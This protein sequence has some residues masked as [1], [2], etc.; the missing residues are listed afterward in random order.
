MKGD[1]EMENDIIRFEDPMQQHFEQIAEEMDKYSEEEQAFIMYYLLQDYINKA[2]EELN[3]TYNEDIVKEM[4]YDNMLK[5]HIKVG[6]EM[7]E[8]LFYEWS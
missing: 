2:S 5:E 6:N 8:V 1:N 4:A 7:R 3:R